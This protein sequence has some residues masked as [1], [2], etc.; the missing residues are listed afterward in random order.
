MRV[1]TLFAML[2]IDQEQNRYQ[3]FL[4]GHSMQIKEMKLNNRCKSR[5]KAGNPC[6]APATV[7]GLCF[8]HANPNKASELGGSGGRSNRHAVAETSVPLPPLDNA[9][10]VRDTAA[11]LIADVMA[12]QVH[13]RIAAGLV[14]LS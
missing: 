7:G 3:L 4:K 8:F 11:R 9:V 12:G 1:M 6:G 2:K 5:T 14:R 13:P 10:A